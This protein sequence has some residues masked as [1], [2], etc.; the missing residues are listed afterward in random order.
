MKYHALKSVIFLTLIGIATAVGLTSCGG[1]GSSG[2]SSSPSTTP[3]MTITPGG[4]PQPQPPPGSTGTGRWSAYALAAFFLMPPHYN[5][6]VNANSAAV[7]RSLALSECNSRHAGSFRFVRCSVVNTLEQTSPV[8]Y[9][10]VTTDF[11]VIPGVLLTHVAF[12]R[13]SLSQLTTDLVNGCNHL[14]RNIG[15]PADCRVAESGCSN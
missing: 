13:L 11:T 5:F 6:I 10:T 9:A 12:D 8:C 2:G 1:G 3:Q 14:N 4:N 15:R 7:A